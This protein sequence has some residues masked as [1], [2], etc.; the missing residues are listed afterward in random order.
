MK[1]SIDF[2]VDLGN[3]LVKYNL[4]PFYNLIH[5]DSVSQMGKEKA[6]EQFVFLNEGKINLEEF[7]YFFADHSLFIRKIFYSEFKKIWESCLLEF[8]HHF[9]S[10]LMELEEKDR[11]YLLSNTEDVHYKYAVKK[12]PQLKEL[13]GHGLSYEMRI[14]KPDK[15]IY[16]KAS[17]IFGLRPESTVFI[18][19]MEENVAAAEQ[20]GFYGITHKDLIR[21]RTQYEIMK[22]KG[23]SW[24]KRNY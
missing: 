18:D 1:N 8:D 9:F 20:F 22:E 23:Q 2:L 17:E 21:T 12:W 14:M 15:L 5:Q 7:F 6:G 13:N 4:D 16:K 19:D 11:V 24:L 10:W 3:V